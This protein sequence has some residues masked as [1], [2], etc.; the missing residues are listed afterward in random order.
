MAVM[1]KAVMGDER[2]VERGIVLSDV[3]L[4]GIERIP[5]S[6]GEGRLRRESGLEE[7]EGSGGSRVLVETVNAAI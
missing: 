6:N 5:S 2:G 7:E 3:V 1:R 4:K